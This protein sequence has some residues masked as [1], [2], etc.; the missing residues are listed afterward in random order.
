VFLRTRFDL[1]KKM[2]IFPLLPYFRYSLV[3]FFLDLNI[4]SSRLECTLSEYMALIYD[5]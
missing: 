3:N 5:I 4:P 1:T 2:D